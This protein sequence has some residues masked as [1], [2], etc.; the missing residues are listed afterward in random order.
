MCGRLDCEL[1]CIRILYCYF[2][3]IFK[4]SFTNRLRYPAPPVKNWRIFHQQIALCV[5]DKNFHL[6]FTTSIRYR[7]KGLFFCNTVDWAC[8]FLPSLAT[9]VDFQLSYS[10]NTR[11]GDSEDNTVEENSSVFSLIQLRW[12]PSA[13]ACRQ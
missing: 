3:P 2:R 4:N 11:Y 1:L 9:T 5:F 6:I 8:S 13:R 7:S 10:A 12:L